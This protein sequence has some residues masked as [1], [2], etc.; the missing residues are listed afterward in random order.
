MT[1]ASLF[2]APRD[3]EASCRYAYGTTPLDPPGAHERGDGFAV[4]GPRGRRGLI[5]IC[6]WHH[7][8]GPPRSHRNQRQFL[9]SQPPWTGRSLSGLHVIPLRWTSQ[10]PSNVAAVSQFAAPRDGEASFWFAYDTTSLV[11]PGAPE[12]GDSFAIRSPQGR[13][14]LILICVSRYSAGPARSPRT[15]RQFRTSQPPQGRRGLI[16]ICV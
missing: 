6:V 5:L 9:S 8:A 11:L 2:A 4:R 15:W 14:G 12:R 1:T 10:E 13:R 16:L 3:G 7:S